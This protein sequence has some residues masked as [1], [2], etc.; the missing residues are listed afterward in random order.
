MSDL[1]NKSV[2]VIESGIFMETA[3][4]LSREFGRVFY[5]NPCSMKGFPHVADAVVGNGIEEI[6]TMDEVFDVT[7][8]LYVFP[9]I[10]YSGLQ[11]HLISMGRRVWGSREGDELELK[12]AW[13]KRVL[14][15][16]GLEVG[17]YKVVFGISELRDY[18]KDKEDKYVKISKYRGSMES[19]HFINMDLSRG[20]LDA[21]ALELGGVQNEVPLIVEDPIDAVVELG[22]D[23]F[24]IDGE[25]PS[26]AVHGIECKDSSY[27]GCRQKYK[28]LPESVREINAALSSVL[29]E[30]RYRNW[31]STEIR[32]SEDGKAYFID[33]CCRQPSPAGESQLELYSNLGE[34]MWD[35]SAGGLVDP[36]FTAQFAVQARLDHKGDKCQ[37]RQLEIPGAFRQWVKLR[38]ACKVG[39]TW[40]IVPREPYDES[41]GWVVGIGDTIQDA[42]N[43]AQRTA[44]ALEGQDVKVNMEALAESLKAVREEEKAGIE[45]TDQEV[46]KPSTVIDNG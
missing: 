16:A 13:F 27:I 10:Q 12:R 44:D 41:I 25:F 18:L 35:G 17:P 26:E 32:E 23:G 6:E 31:W 9:D 1:R 20:K 37:W 11:N 21:L 39:N 42:I 34:I 40:N 29:K 3:I 28:D 19:F 15:K 5:V 46:P 7:P 8:D 36:K 22:Y 38:N 2:M 30:Y 4:R 24:C 45:F 14:I 33:P 43:H